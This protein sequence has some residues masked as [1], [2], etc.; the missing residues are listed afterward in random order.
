MNKISCDVCMDLA[1]LVQDNV[2]SEDSKE[3]V[4]EHIKECKDCQRL[5]NSFEEAAPKMDEE[6]ILKKIKKQL[7]VGAMVIISLGAMIGLALSESMGMFY[8]ILIMPT[9]GAI[10]YLALRKKAY[11]VP[12]ILLGFSYIWILIKYI[13][14]GMFEETPLLYGLTI[15]FYWGLIYSGLCVLGILIGSL[16]HIAFRKEEAK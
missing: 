9:I 13:G 15:P 6:K 7:F 10:G 8:N 2:A 11:L 4:Y 12:L 3:I 5:F 1:P 16:F 14:E